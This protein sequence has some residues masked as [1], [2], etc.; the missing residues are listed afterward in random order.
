MAG[1]PDPTTLSQGGFPT[2]AGLTKL[3]QAVATVAKERVVDPVVNTARGVQNIMTGQTPMYAA[4]ETGRV[5]FNPEVVGTTNDV[6]LGMMGG[7]GMVGAKQALREGIDP[8]RLG[9]FFGP[10]ARTANKKALATARFMEK[11]GAPREEIIGT[12]DWFR[13]GVDNKWRFEVPDTGFNI[14]DDVKA[15]LLADYKTGGA[16]RRM[17]DLL[18]NLPLFDAYPQLKSKT[19]GLKNLEDDAIG[20]ATEQGILYSPDLFADSVYRPYANRTTLHELQH[21]VQRVE[22]F[23]PGANFGS[24]DYD[25]RLREDLARLYDNPIRKILFAPSAGKTKNQEILARMNELRDS[26][27][28]MGPTKEEKYYQRVSGEVEARNVERRFNE[29]YTKRPWETEDVPVEKQF[30]SFR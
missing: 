30:L 16:P 26:P 27:N 7:S 23:G 17:G 15:A 21:L 19:L 24:F 11:K 28:P 5:T 29:G 25:R 22:N 20:E 4:D 13:G 8:S 3:G 18:P 12:T 10:D 2:R 6:A 1:M 14:P 9:M